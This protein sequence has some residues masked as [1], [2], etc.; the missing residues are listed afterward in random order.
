MVNSRRSGVLSADKAHDP[1]I[2]LVISLL[3]LYII[4]KR[5]R[6]SVRRCRVCYRGMG[7]E[8][9]KEKEEL[10]IESE[11]EDQRSIDGRIY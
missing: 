7:T 5:E 11:I 8:Q 3:H 10:E 1:T 9:N 2:K 6:P 4:L